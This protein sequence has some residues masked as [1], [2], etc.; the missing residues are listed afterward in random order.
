MLE[1][2][3]RLWCGMRNHP[4]RRRFEPPVDLYYS[5]D[6]PLPPHLICTNC[7][8]VLQRRLARQKTTL[9]P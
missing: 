9:Q 4:C 6:H 5:G 3:R 8:K 2:L 7:E 1:F